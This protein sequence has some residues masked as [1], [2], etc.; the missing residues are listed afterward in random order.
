MAGLLTRSSS[1]N[2][3]PK[4]LSG[5]LFASQKN[6]IQQRDCMGFSPN[7]LLIKCMNQLQ[8][9]RYKKKIKTKQYNKK[10]EIILHHV[11]PSHLKNLINF[12]ERAFERSSSRKI[13]P[14]M[15]R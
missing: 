3:F 2:A 8:V 15:N 6:Y 11:K 14:L 4:K 7:S 10:S 1:A 9:Q 13:S 5:I 12:F